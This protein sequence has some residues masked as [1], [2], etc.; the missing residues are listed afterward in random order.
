MCQTTLLFRKRASP[1]KRVEKELIHRWE[2]CC[3]PMANSSSPQE[4]GTPEPGMAK[5]KDPRRLRWVFSG[6]IRGRG[7]I[8]KIIYCVYSLYVNGCP[9]YEKNGTHMQ[10]RWRE[11]GCQPAP[12]ARTGW[13]RLGKTGFSLWPRCAV[14]LVVR[15]THASPPSTA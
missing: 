1:P 11:T 5:K 9:D 14:A 10:I 4:L 15:T 7:S 13:I 8:L 3:A 12:H 2:G 6:T